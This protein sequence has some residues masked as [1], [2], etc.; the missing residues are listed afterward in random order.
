VFK[1]Q[2]TKALLWSDVI[3]KIHAQM[4]E[5][6]DNRKNKPFNRSKGLLSRSRLALWLEKKLHSNFQ[7]FLVAW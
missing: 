5:L 1:S 4:H 2:I 7:V 6:E 3:Q